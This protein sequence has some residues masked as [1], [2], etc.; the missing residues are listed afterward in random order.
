MN[1]P[2]KSL[3]RIL[4]YVSLLFPLSVLFP[5]LSKEVYFISLFLLF[6]SVFLEKKEIH[7]PRI[8]INFL[9]AFFILVFFLTVNLF[10]F[11]EKALETLLL[12]LS[13][14]FLEKKTFRDYFQIYLIEFL[15]LCGA[16]FYYAEFYF[17]ILLALGFIYFGYALFLHLYLEEGE[18][19]VITGEEFRAIFFSFGALLFLSFLLSAVF[20]IGLPRLQVPLFNV[21]VEREKAKTGFTDKIRLGSFSEI[22]ESSTPILRVIFEEDFNPPPEDLYFKVISFDYFDG[23]VWKRTLSEEK[24]TP[25]KP[26]VRPFK[27]AIFYLL[28]SQEDYLPIFE[29]TLFIKASFPFK[30]YGDGIVKSP[31]PLNYPVKYEIYF[32]EKGTKALNDG[33]IFPFLERYLQL[34]EVSEK[35]RE[36]AG[37]LKGKDERRL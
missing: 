12:L 13:L 25:L 27:K 20:F 26:P 29:R 23:R 37:K 15:I 34:P 2:R 19:R 33:D 10:N 21:G 18:V 4:I 8:L 16:S 5:I 30:H 17:F 22:Q 31:E 1:L 24:E 32:S 7:L 36:L 35:I 9:G 14:K 28:T 11:L 3:E 6:L